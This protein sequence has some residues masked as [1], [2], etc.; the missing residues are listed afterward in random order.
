MAQQQTPTLMVRDEWD[1]GAATVTVRGEIDTTTAGV[2]S[3][4]L[5]WVV[6]MDP[7]RLVIDLA[8][9]CFLDSCAVHALADIWHMLPRHCP[10]VLRSPNRQ[11]RRVFEVTGLDAVCVIE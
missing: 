2:L 3:E 5:D 6:R 11:A 1:D 7:E 8:Q 4:C 9:V 10:L